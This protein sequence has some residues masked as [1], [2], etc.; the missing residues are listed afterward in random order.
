MGEV[1]HY[2]VD[3]PGSV[4]RSIGHRITEF[5]VRKMFQSLGMSSPRDTITRQDF[6]TRI[7]KSGQVGGYCISAV[8]GQAY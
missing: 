3:D 7:V 1:D 8:G 6:V 2:F 4:Q 5:V